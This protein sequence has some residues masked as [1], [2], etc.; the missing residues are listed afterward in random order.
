MHHDTSIKKIIFS[1]NEGEADVA[2]VAEADT[3]QVSQAQF[4][5][6]DEAQPGTGVNVQ[7]EYCGILWHAFVCFMTLPFCCL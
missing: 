4:E 5:V 6:Q 3:T 7:G 1:T 2:I